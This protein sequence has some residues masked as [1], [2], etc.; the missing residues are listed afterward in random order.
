MTTPRAGASAVTVLGRI[1][2]MGG[3]DDNLP[4]L[5]SVECFTFGVGLANLT[6][7][8]VPDMI[9]CRSNFAACVDDDKIVVVG[10]FKTDLRDP[11]NAFSGVCKDVEVFHPRENIWKS[12]SKLNVA[13]SALAV[14]NCDNEQLNF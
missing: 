1:Y 12:S 8:T 2:V 13:R 14:V 4:G 3:V 9:D 7:H 10:G 6:W 11:N 5:S